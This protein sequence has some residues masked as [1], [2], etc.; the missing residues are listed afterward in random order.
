MKAEPIAYFTEPDEL[1]LVEVD[2][3]LEVEDPPLFLSIRSA[4]IL[5]LSEI[6]SEMFFVIMC[7]ITF[8]TE[9]LLI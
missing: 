7:G 6:G 9:G 5:L 3:L 1:D 4:A 8:V 2:D